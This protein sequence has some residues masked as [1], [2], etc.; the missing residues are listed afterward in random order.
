MTNRQPERLLDSIAEAE[1]FRVLV[2]GVTDYAIYM[3]TPEGEIASWNA[4]AQ[5]FKGYGPSEVIGRHY[6]MFFSPGDR[7][8]ASSNPKAGASARTA[9]A[10]GP[11]WC[12]TRCATTT[13]S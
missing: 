4:G 5:R 13:A 12:S 8:K 3:L 10:S 9:P 6:S 7:A 11:A 2:A 1:R